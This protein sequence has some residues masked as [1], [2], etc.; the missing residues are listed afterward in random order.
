MRASWRRR[1][2][3]GW[4]LKMIA[5]SVL[6]GSPLSSVLPWGSYRPGFCLCGLMQSARHVPG[7]GY[8]RGRRGNVQMVDV[9]CSGAFAQ[10]WACM[11]LHP[12]TYVGDAWHRYGLVS[13][14]VQMIQLPLW[15]W[16]IQ[17]AL[18]ERRWASQCALRVWCADKP[19]V[20]EQ[21]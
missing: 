9:F 17:L 13:Y 3:L 8:Y 6:V 1:R 12:H 7:R 19:D 4:I 15:G 14:P 11:R 16:T 5:L 2:R 18:V 21:R 10:N 20:E